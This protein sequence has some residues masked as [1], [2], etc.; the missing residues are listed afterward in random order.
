MIYEKGYDQ[1]KFMFVQ[2]IIR[3]HMA[4]QKVKQNLSLCLLKHHATKAYRGVE[5]QLHKFLTASLHG[6]KLTAWRPR[7]FIPENYTSV[8]A[9]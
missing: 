8:P 3:Q 9:G 2:D 1:A 6:E 4:N 7:R 5:V